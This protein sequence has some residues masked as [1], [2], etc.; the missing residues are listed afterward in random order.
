MTKRILIAAIVMM[1]AVIAQAQKLPPGKWWRRP[2]VVQELQLTSEQQQRL[3]DLFRAAA[4]ELIDAKAAVDKLQVALRGELDRAQVRRQEVQRIAG[5]LNDARGRLFERE[6]MMLVD[7]R[8]VLT[9]QQWMRMRTKL[10]QMREREGPRD[11]PLPRRR[12]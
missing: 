2:E 6:L 9:E 11:R 1:A 3:D 7:M 12:R 5:Q 8:G 4:D 10:D